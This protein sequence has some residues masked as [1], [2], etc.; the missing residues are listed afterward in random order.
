MNNKKILNF[1]AGLFV[2]LLMIVPTLND[3]TTMQYIVSVVGIGGSITVYEKIGKI[4]AQEKPIYIEDWIKEVAVGTVFSITFIERSKS[5]DWKL[6]LL[7]TSDTQI[8]MLVTVGTGYENGTYQ[9]I[10]E[11]ND[12]KNYGIKF[13]S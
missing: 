6:C 3:Y 8:E 2:I 7:R 13:I 4:S 1:A 5:S 10:L 12:A 11:P 9:K